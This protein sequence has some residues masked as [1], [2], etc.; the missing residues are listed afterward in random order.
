[1]I[2]KKRQI[3]TATL[4]IALLAAVTVNWY[5]NNS[6]I[7][8]QDITTTSNNSVTHNLGDSVLV[9][10]TTLNAEGSSDS[11]NE[12]L[13]ADAKI[14]RKNSED[15]IKDCIDDILES[16]KLTEKDK[17]DINKSFDEY[18]NVIKTTSD[19]E[20]LI[21]A[22]TGRDCIVIINQGNCQVIVEKNSLNDAVILQI[23]EII[24][25][26]T[27]IFAENLTIIE[28]K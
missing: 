6:D 10:G 8:K 24:Q 17:T 22:K 26:N 16:D 14:S 19:A 13:F 12:Q 1:M 4:I 15:K 3:L 20:N 7:S 2:V 23:T 28:S 27:N 11:S 25:K 5:Y 9:A 21:K 18:M